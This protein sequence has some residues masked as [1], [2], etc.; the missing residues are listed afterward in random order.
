MIKKLLPIILILSGIVFSQ[1]ESYVIMVSF[2]GFRYNYTDRVHTPSFDYMRDHGVKAESLHPVFPTKTFP[3]HYS[4]ATGAYTQTHML[5]GNSFYDQK[6]KEIYSIG[7]RETV[8]DPKWYQAEPIWVTAERQGVRAASFFWVGSEAPIKGLSPSITKMYDGSV[9]FE[10]RVDSVIQWLQLPEEKRPHLIMLYFSEPDHVGHVSGPESAETDSVI[11]DMD[12]LLG[13][14]LD[15]VKSLSISDQVNLV[16]VSDH[17]MTALNKDKYVIIDDYLN[18]VNDYYLDIVGPY[19]QV[20]AKSWISRLFIGK[21][22]STMPSVA[23]YAKRNI[24]DRYHFV[25]RNTGDFLI[26]ADKGW[27]IMDQNRFDKRGG[28]E[29]GNHGFA[30]EIKELHAIFY[31]MGP[32]IKEGLM[33]D[34]FENIH[35]YP[36]ICE[37]LEIQPYANAPDAPEGRLEIL[38]PI[39][40]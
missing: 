30:P 21:K 31:A 35:V 16:I 19:A 8:Q 29:G 36:L 40:K 11:L 39:L 13:K 26:V 33:I 9:P 34:T 14:L 22:L 4:L 37:L 25:N 20:T 18:D 17:G 23:V 15:G 1:D 12:Q 2:D 32:K 5:T 3:N 10:S 6:F 24:P 38:A 28:P 27:T 7:D